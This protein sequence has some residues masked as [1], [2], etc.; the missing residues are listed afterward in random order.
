MAD[1]ALIMPAR[2]K[3]SH[4]EAAVRAAL[5]TTATGIDIVLSDQGSTDGTR[6]I[7]RRVATEYDGPNRVILL[8]CPLTDR[9]GLAG[10]N[11]HLAWIMD[12]VDA[13]FFV[14]IGADDLSEPGLA[15]A[16]VKIWRSHDADYVGALLIR[17]LPDGTE[18]SRGGVPPE[19]R[20][21]RLNARLDFRV[22]ASEHLYGM[23]GGQCAGAFSRR[24]IDRW[25][26]L[27]TW[28]GIDILL[29]FMAALDDGK[30]GG[31][32]CVVN[33]FLYRYV[34]HGA[35]DN[36]GLEGRMRAADEA[37]DAAEKLRLVECQQYEILSLY[38]YLGERAAE[39]VPGFEQSEANRALLDCIARRACIFASCRDALTQA[40]IAPLGL[41]I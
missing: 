26:P 36:A 9:V 35:V 40:R 31:G 3:A 5:A 28:Y 34:E 20:G 33:D 27:D 29:P 1:A 11:R 23:V 16:C 39:L 32:F 6:D 38:R 2:N 8:D 30:G 17:Q 22:G 21:S 24:L 41:A 4:V 7:L 37:G 14:A 25:R 13:E 12:Q 10:L 19:L 15:A 18:T